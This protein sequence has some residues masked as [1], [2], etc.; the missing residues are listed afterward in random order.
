VE[1]GFALLFRS[2]V[3]EYRSDSNGLERSAWKEALHHLSTR[4]FELNTL[5]RALPDQ[6]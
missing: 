4:K 1:D 6:H 5:C 3:S 2:E